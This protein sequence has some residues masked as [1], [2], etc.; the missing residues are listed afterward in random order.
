MRI[1][2]AVATLVCAG[3]LAVALAVALESSPAGRGSPAPGGPS[4]AGRASARPSVSSTPAPSP[5][6]DEAD[7]YKFGVLDDP[8]DKTFNQLLGINDLG[9]VVGYFGSGAARHPS[10]GY[11]LRPPYL[12]PR[13]QS[14]NFPGSVQT[15]VTGLNNQGVQVGF[16]S[17]QNNASEL[18]DNFGFYLLGGRFHEV[19]FPG[20]GSAR[21]PVNQLLGVND[22]DIAVGFYTDRQGRRHGYRYDIATRKFAAVAVPGGTSVIAAAIDN[23][24]GVAGFFTSSKGVTSGFFVPRTGQMFTLNAPHATSTQALGVNDSGEVVGDYRTGSG[25]SAATHGFTWSRGRGFTTVED[26]Q[27]VGTTTVNGINDG[28]DLVGFYVDA[29]GDTDGFL[30]LPVL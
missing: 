14:I 24:G 10:K 11:V 28:G 5:A 15:Q 17:A 26:P 27:G 3:A 21:P 30:A 29:A 16:W 9:H 22:H 6:A 2:L 25:S 20:S 19:N 7:G 23:S 12:Q 18:N 1:L 8:G 4:A 13:Y